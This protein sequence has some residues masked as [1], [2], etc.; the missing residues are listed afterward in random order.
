MIKL[1]K[2]KE[3]RRNRKVYNDGIMHDQ[4]INIDGKNG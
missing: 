3:L 4:A 1:I 2:T